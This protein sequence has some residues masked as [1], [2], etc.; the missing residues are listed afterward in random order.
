M[1]LH[2]LDYEQQICRNSSILC[3][4]E[5][6]KWDLK[7]N[8]KKHLELLKDKSQSQGCIRMPALPFDAENYLPDMLDMKKGIISE[9]VNQL[10]DWSLV[11][12]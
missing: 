10:V 5:N 11:Q 2:M 12:K 4:S 7:R 9:L 6:K 8:Y 3:I 1:S